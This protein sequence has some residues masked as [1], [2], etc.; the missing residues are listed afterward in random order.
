MVSQINTQ[1]EKMDL[2]AKLEIKGRR[3]GASYLYGEV[4]N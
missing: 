3:G 1:F 2:D 4:Q